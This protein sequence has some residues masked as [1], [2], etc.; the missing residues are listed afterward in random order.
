V[1]VYFFQNPLSFHKDAMPAAKATTAAHRQGKFWEMHDKC[2]ANMKALNA[3]NFAKW[4]GELGLDMAQFNKDMADPKLE[5]EIKRQQAAMVALGARG[6]PGFFVNGEQVKGAQPFPK[7][8]EVI[9][10]HIA[11]VDA[12]IK[13]GKSRSAAWQ[14][15]ARSSHAQGGNF[16]KWVVRGEPAPAGQAAPAA[17]NKPKR[18]VA[19]NTVWKVGVN[20][21]DG[22]KGGKEPLVTIVEFS[23]FQ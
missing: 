20:A 19:D 5:A 9:D 1:A 10:K 12:A 13:G 14:E 7:F 6:T 4:A 3:D 16:L 18:P 11:K 17:G 15:D 8:K 23:E 22:K 21:A 2:F